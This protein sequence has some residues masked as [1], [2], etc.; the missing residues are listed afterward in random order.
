MHSRFISKSLFPNVLTAPTLGPNNC[1]VFPL[2]HVWNTPI[3]CLPADINSDTYLCLIKVS[4]R[5]SPPKETLRYLAPL[6]AEIVEK[7]QT[8]WVGWKE[9]LR[10]WCP[11]CVTRHREMFGWHSP[12]N[13]CRLPT[14]YQLFAVSEN[15]SGI[16]ASGCPHYANVHHGWC[17]LFRFRFSVVS[18]QVSRLSG[19]LNDN[20]FIF[21]S[22]RY[23]YDTFFRC[24]ACPP[25]PIKKREI[26]KQ[27][28]KECFS[29]ED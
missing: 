27:R 9:T 14:L 28:R 20:P 1:T 2:D 5:Y 4:L 17:W 6:R 21:F 19:L 18:R 10:L 26:F 22:S 7:Y 12:L 25:K 16:S 8:L 3:D 15:L 13:F 23:P 11:H 29:L 24:F